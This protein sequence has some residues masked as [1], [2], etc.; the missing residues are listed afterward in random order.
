M[1]NLD[2]IEHEQQHQPQELPIT[3]NHVRFQPTSQQILGALP[4]YLYKSV[5]VCVCVLFSVYFARFQY[6]F[7]CISYRF[8]QNIYSMLV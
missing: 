1:D 3:N 5:C 4:S 7:Q 6:E 2:L 8:S